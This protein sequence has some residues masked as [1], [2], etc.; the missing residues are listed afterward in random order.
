MH[1]F[2]LN[3]SALINHVAKENRFYKRHET[4]CDMSPKKKKDM[5]PSIYLNSKILK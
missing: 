2:R 1:V 5:N 4:S 3:F